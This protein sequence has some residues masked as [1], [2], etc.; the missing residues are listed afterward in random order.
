MSTF[1]TSRVLALVLLVAGQSSVSATPTPSL[2]R[3]R[4]LQSSQTEIVIDF[5]GY[6]A[7]DKLSDL[8]GGTH[9]SGYQCTKKDK[10]KPL[11]CPLQENS[12]NHAMIFDSSNPTGDGTYCSSYCC[13][14]FIIV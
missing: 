9:I 3:G 12:K 2:L 4:K 5:E 1:Q 7:G 13:I 6:K 14:L 8:G 11:N 10:K